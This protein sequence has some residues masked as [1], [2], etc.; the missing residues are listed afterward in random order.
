[1]VLDESH[2][3]NYISSFYCNLK[4]Y[5]IKAHSWWIYRWEYIYTSTTEVLKRATKQLE[6]TGI[7]ITPSACLLQCIH[8]VQKQELSDDFNY[9]Y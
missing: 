4:H 6:R 5:M 2:E 9:G 1:M 7:C 3:S 8:G